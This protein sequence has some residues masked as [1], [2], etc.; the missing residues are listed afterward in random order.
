VT[1]VGDTLLDVDWTGEVTRLCPDA[2]APVLDHRA[3]HAR[4]GGAGLAACFAAEAG[5]RVH[6][7]TALGTDPEADLLRA[8]LDEAGVRVVDLGLD[9]PTP[10]KLRLRAGERSLVRVDRACTPVLAPGPWSDDASAAVLAADAVL[11]SDYGRTLAAQPPLGALLASLGERIPVVWD[12]HPRGPVPPGGL[13]VMVPNADEARRLAGDGDGDG[14][15]DEAVA[16]RLASRFGCSVALTTGGAGAVLA[17]PGRPPRRMPTA[18]ASG[19]PCGAGDRFAAS[20]AVARARGT[21]TAEAVAAA[22]EDAR[23]QVLAGFGTGAGRVAPG[24]RLRLDGDGGAAPDDPATLAA[25]VRA[26]GGTVVVAGGCFDVLHAG[27]VRLLEAA[28]RLG[29]CLIVCVN[30]DLSV[31][32]LKGRHRPVNPVEDRVAVL[33]ALAPVDA[34]TVFEEDTPAEALATLRPHVFVK[35]ADHA[36]AA[37]GEI[38]EAVVLRRWG[39]EVVFVPLVPGRSTTR[40]LQAAATGTTG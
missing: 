34:V 36:D 10:V 31:R 12:P 3:D 39:G 32:R 5:A 29:D 27:H 38:P 11:I 26:G 9:G 4:P 7:V 18:P 6:L 19:D 22:V 8:R 25:R 40:I 15:D 30:G 23:R 17:A 1:V 13:D 14:A 21:G 37:G 28:R 35:G 33:A 24:L 16:A 2:P 20:L